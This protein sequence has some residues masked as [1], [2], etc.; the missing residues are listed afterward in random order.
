M[1]KVYSQS[2]IAI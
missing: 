1:N 2:P